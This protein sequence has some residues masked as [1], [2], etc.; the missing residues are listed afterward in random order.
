MRFAF[1][2]TTTEKDYWEYN[3][4]MAFRSPYVR[5]TN[6]WRRSLFVAV[7]LLFSLSYFLVWGFT[8]DALLR[9]IP[10]ALILGILALFIRPLNLLS[11]KMYMNKLKRQEKPLYSPHSDIVFYEDRLEETTPVG[12]HEYIYTAID[13][14]SVMRNRTVYIH[15]NRAIGYILPLS[16]FASEEE[17]AAFIV[18]IKEKCDKITVYR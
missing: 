18:F 17:Q 14:I 8:V 3:T 5:R 2:I 10:Y 7:F 15:A 9:F 6:I 1:H 4:F 16:C 12:K 13:R 11:L